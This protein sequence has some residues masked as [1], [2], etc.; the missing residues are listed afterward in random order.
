MPPQD[1]PSVRVDSEVAVEEPDF[2]PKDCLRLNSPYMLQPKPI[3]IE[4]TANILKP[5]DSS[6]YLDRS[7]AALGHDFNYEWMKEDPNFTQWLSPNQSQL[8]LQIFEAEGPKANRTSAALFVV[9]QLLDHQSS[10]GHVKPQVLYFFC[11]RSDPKR[12]TACAVLK[13]WMYQLLQQRPD[14]M[15][16]FHKYLFEDS[17]CMP[18]NLS[19]ARLMWAYLRR[20]AKQDDAGL[21]Y[22][23]LDGLDEC[24]KESRTLLLELLNRPLPYEGCPQTKP[25][26]K[27][28]VTARASLGDEKYATI[29]LNRTKAASAV[30][31]NHSDPLPDQL[32][33]LSVKD[34]DKFDELKQILAAHVYPPTV[35]QFVAIFPEGEQSHILALLK[36]FPIPEPVDTDCLEFIHSELWLANSLS[37][38]NATVHGKLARHYLNMI[39]ADLPGISM[40]NLEGDDQSVWTSQISAGLKY[41][42]SHWADHVKLSLDTSA[43]LMNLIL[44]TFNPDS[45]TIE[46]WW[47]MFMTWSYDISQYFDL[48]KHNTTPLHLFAMF[49]LSEL[50]RAAGPPSLIA[51]YIT[52]EDAQQ[53]EPL[54][55]AI[56]HN[57]T[58][59]AK[60]LIASRKPT[61]DFHCTF[62]TTSNAELEKSIFEVHDERVKT[63]EKRDAEMMLRHASYTGD[64][65]LLTQTINFL[66]RKSPAGFFPR[67]DTTEVEFIIDA[68]DHRLLKPM[69]TIINIQAKA[70]H[71]IECTVSQQ[72][73]RMLEEVLNNRIIQHMIKSR[74]ICLRPALNSVLMNKIP[75]M[76]ALLLNEHTID[77]RDDTGYL[78]LQVAVKYPSIHTLK[79]FAA[80]QNFDFNHGT[81]EEGVALNLMLHK[82]GKEVELTYLNDMLARGARMRYEHFGMTAL[83][84]A[85]ELGETA[86]METLLDN[87]NDEEIKNDINCT[88]SACHKNKGRQGKT[89]LAIAA[90]LG[91]DEI[92]RLLL[93]KGANIAVVDADGKTAEDLAREA[94]KEDVV[95]VFEE[96]EKEL[97][98]GG[99]QGKGGAKSGAKGEGKGKKKGKGGNK[100]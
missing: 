27:V 14:M 30:P 90:M 98:G 31:I 89:A 93:D 21:T 81:I 66:N 13:G 26:F 35:E 28:L 82:A 18:A 38:D 41:A 12:S 49:G 56:L 84:V 29:D 86:T 80:L 79:L 33:N 96:F 3:S 42:V 9:G 64:Q 95:G 44:G 58:D 68:G 99:S 50:L 63:L 4:M 100:K 36:S 2:I 25:S 74:Q 55:V 10:R 37:N 6:R 40:E 87:L 61:T 62:A 43:D 92:V 19:Q 71:I 39:S 16:D 20:A 45:D 54:D 77:A 46:K 53:L 67:D 52:T 22:C 65:E 11:H 48:E 32:R 34:E 72:E 24:D 69:L 73:P 8:R 1:V 51:N 7:K 76:S 85:A 70:Q 15:N 59:I 75:S 17:F 57:H 5:F 60:I 88:V 83:H 47:I 91:H 78:P 23:V 97:M 94:G